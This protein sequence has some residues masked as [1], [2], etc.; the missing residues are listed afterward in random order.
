M[1]SQLVYVSDRCG[2]GEDVPVTV[3]GS[4]WRGAPLL[5]GTFTG[6]V[7]KRWPG[8]PLKIPVIEPVLGPAAKMCYE[9]YGKFGEDDAEALAA[10]FPEFSYDI[11][12]N[13]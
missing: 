7:E 6:L 10:Q 9:K 12:K 5:F 11:N 8:R 13:K 2:A 4:V 1:Y 3:S